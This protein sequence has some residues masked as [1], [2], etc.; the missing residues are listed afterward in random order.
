VLLKVSE[1]LMRRPDIGNIE[2][3]SL[4]GIPI[5]VRHFV[6]VTPAKLIFFGHGIL[7]LSKAAGLD[8][9]SWILPTALEDMA[10]P[11]RTPY[12]MVG[13]VGHYVSRFSLWVRIRLRRR[14]SQSAKV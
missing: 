2:R 8:E 1:E 10:D 4:V 3:Y 13:Q 9:F 14:S 6:V 11:P 5:R 7:R 12:P